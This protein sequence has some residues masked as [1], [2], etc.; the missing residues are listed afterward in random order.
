MMPSENALKSADPFKYLFKARVYIKF[1]KSFFARRPLSQK[2]R[3]TP[4]GRHG[5]RMMI[6]TEVDRS[7]LVETKIY[8][9][10]FVIFRRQGGGVYGMG[11][12]AVLTLWGG[13]LY[14]RNARIL[15]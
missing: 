8:I 9:A 2:V 13:V 7:L 10:S 5:C 12:R 14:G 15:Y 6:R 1:T 4:T 11:Q 3:K